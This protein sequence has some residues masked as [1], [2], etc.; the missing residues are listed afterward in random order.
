MLL[1]NNTAANRNTNTNASAFVMCSAKVH[2]GTP[3]ELLTVHPMYAC[4]FQQAQR[5]LAAQQFRR[6]SYIS[7]N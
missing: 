6:D 3:Q 4:A 2:A 7:L 1:Q 5:I